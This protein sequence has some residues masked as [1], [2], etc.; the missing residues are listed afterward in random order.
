VNS[1]LVAIDVCNLCVGVY[2]DKGEVDVFLM[3]TR[4]TTRVWENKTN[5][6][7]TAGDVTHVIATIFDIFH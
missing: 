6:V 1:G 5:A 3:Q 7:D 2:L 4:A